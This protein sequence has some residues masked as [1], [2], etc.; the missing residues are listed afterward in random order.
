MAQT[1][2]QRNPQSQT[3]NTEPDP[4]PRREQPG[5]VKVSD[6]GAKVETPVPEAAK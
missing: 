2:V 6:A 1:Q 5:E 3:W 4:E